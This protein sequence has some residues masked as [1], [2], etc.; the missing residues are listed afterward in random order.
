MISVLPI[1]CYSDRIWHPR[2]A[3]LHFL[4]YLY[5]D[6]DGFLVFDQV[7]QHFGIVVES[8]YLCSLSICILA[9]EHIAIS[10]HAR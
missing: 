7:I 4:V 1:F 8:A 6:F 2:G 9:L 5:V 3:P 10:C